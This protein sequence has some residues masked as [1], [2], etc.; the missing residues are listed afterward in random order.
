M[1]TKGYII[2][3]RHAILRLECHIFEFQHRW[4]AF[5]IKLCITH[6]RYDVVSDHHLCQFMLVCFI[7]PHRVH[8]NTVAHDDHPVGNCHHLF[9]LVCDEYDGM[10]F[11][12][13]FFDKFHQ[14]V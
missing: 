7:F 6:R 4:Q 1:Y 13:I 14:Q 2:D 3:H 12:C 5:K 11:G 8:H 10:P 9:E